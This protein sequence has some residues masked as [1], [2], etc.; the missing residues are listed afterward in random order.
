[1]GVPQ[2]QLGLDLRPE[3]CGPL[4]AELE[5]LVAWWEGQ[6]CVPLARARGLVEAVR[7]LPPGAEAFIA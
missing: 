3:V 6:D 1:M 2:V 7:E 4:I 5:A